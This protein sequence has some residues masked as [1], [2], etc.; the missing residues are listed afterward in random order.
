MSHFINFLKIENF[1]SIKSVQIDCE[2][3][4]L[5]IGRP[6][7]G[8]SNILEAL[9]LISHTESVGKIFDGLI[10]FNSIEDIFRDNDTS[11]DISIESN[12]GSAKLKYFNS[13]KTYGLL[14]D[15]TG[16]NTFSE[17]DE[18]DSMGDAIHLLDDWAQS[19]FESKS[20]NTGFRA[21]EFKSNGIVTT[22]NNNFSS[23]IRRYSYRRISKH[24]NTFVGFL[25]PP[26]GD[27]LLRIF[28]SHHKLF[29]EAALLFSEYGLDLVTV[30]N[31]KKIVLQKKI[32]RRAYQLPYSLAA[33]T[34]QRI[35]FHLAAI[36]SN[37]NSIL[38]FE[39][40]EA[41]A[42]PPYVQQLAEAIAADESNQFFIATHSPYILDTLMN[43]K[44]SVAVFL[45]DYID[46][47]TTIRQLTQD[48]IDGV[49]RYHTNI[50]FNL[51]KFKQAE[52]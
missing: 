18:C 32:G 15:F 31:E 9:S 42:F 16:R 29:D 22:G 2:K 51:D 12:I 39:E 20:G 33:D 46:Y 6:N 17:L 23:N 52:S 3:I 27:N 25:H 26:L 7:T 34:L 24:D 43:Q 10:Y 37:Q 30:E 14:C 8:K 4:N 44:N 35:I 47:Q 38:L 19:P 1:K 11:L 50:F 36:H 40:P 41:H 28:D 13:E 5:F 21:V 49:L 48:D 45:V